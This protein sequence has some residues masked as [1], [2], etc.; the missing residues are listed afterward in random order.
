[1]FEKKVSNS[2]KEEEISLKDI[3]KKIEKRQ[4]EL[5][6]LYEGINLFLKCNSNRIIRN[7]TKYLGD[8]WFSS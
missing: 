6:K 7:G 4:G 1:M 8:C 2:Q 5:G 3:V